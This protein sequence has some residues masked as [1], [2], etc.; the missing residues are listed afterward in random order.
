MIPET[1]WCSICE[2][3]IWQQGSVPLARA[4][5]E[6][7]SFSTWGLWY[8]Q[9]GCHRQSES[10]TSRKGLSHLVHSQDLHPL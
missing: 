8:K 5:E 7:C 9:H 3:R 1:W 6:E 10:H 2:A 4:G